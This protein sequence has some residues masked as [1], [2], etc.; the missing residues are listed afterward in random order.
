MPERASVPLR[1]LL[2][3]D[4]AA[5]I[6][7]MEMALELSS[8]TTELLVARDG[9]EAL[10]LLERQGMV[11]PPLLAAGGTPLFVSG[12][13]AALVERALARLGTRVSRRGWVE[14]AEFLETVD[15]LVCP[16]TVAESF[17]LVAA[18]AMAARVPVVVTDAGAL[19]EVVGAEHPYTA[20]AGDPV[21]LACVLHRALDE[22]GTPAGDTAVARARRRW[23]T[24]WS[25]DAG[26]ARIAALLT[27]L[28]VLP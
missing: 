16:S 6:F 17:G 25:P 22:L 28:G 27:E 1:L 10:E 4:N 19:P 2:V 12:S 23:E 3:E 11:P 20:R 24:L 21:S 8:V 5:D 7:L 15:V 13:G 9:L 14:R 18:E 26:R